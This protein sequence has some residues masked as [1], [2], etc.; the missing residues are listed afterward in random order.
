MLRAQETGY[1]M[2]ARPSGKG[3]HVVPH[4]GETA[5]GKGFKKKVM[6][7]IKT[8]FGYNEDNTPANKTVQT[9]RHCRRNPGVA[10]AID[11]GSDFR[12]GGVGAN[13][14]GEDVDIADLDKFLLW[15][16]AKRADGAYNAE[17]LG[18][19]ANGVVRAVLFSHSNFMN[20]AFK[21]NKHDLTNNCAIQVTFT[22]ETGRYKMVE[23]PKGG[24][25]VTSFNEPNLEANPDA[26]KLTDIC[27]HGSGCYRY[28]CPCRGAPLVFDVRWLR[29][30]RVWRRPLPSL[31][32]RTGLVPRRGYSK[33]RPYNPAPPPPLPSR[34]RSTPLAWQASHA[35]LRELRPP[36][37]ARNSPLFRRRIRALASCL[38][39]R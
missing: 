12:G 25:V 7:F 34:A 37:F 4:V 3:I 33:R 8:V 5:G 6:G 18:G 2:L 31:F 22:G 16:A 24:P 28:T 35:P 39:A 10:A 26:L 38:P 17:K 13:K 19:L 15:L 36:T 29:Q 21:A 20:V 23:P 11:A 27:E 1:Y 30:R 9:K 32:S 14:P